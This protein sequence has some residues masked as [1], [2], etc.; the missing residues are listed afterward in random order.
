MQE[1]VLEITETVSDVLLFI[2]AFISIQL[3]YG[4]IYAPKLVELEI[5]NTYIEIQLKTEFIWYSKFLISTFIILKKK[6]NNSL[7]LYIKYQD[8]NN[9]K[10]KNSYSMP[11]I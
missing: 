8:V 10:I 11:L 5:Q 4:P 6:H 1:K 7:C 2:L 3:P 9:L